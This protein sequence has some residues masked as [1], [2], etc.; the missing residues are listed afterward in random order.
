[1]DSYP[2]KANP[3]KSLAVVAL[4]P[5]VITTFP[6]TQASA[7][8]ADP[9]SG[10][11]SA[12][13]SCPKT[14][15]GVAQATMANSQGEQRLVQTTYQSGIATMVAVVS[16]APDHKNT[17]LIALD[18]KTDPNP[19]AGRLAALTRD[20]FPEVPVVKR[21]T[22]TASLDP[23]KRRQRSS[24]GWR[25]PSAEDDGPDR[26]PPWSGQQGNGGCGDFL[27]ALFGNHGR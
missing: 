20:C 22:D 23:P 6:I 19:L 15:T 11:A 9:L 18:P 13:L 1:M 12:G 2:C 7:A 21:G 17:Y 14:Q 25:P 16:Q 8:E 5:L 4:L 27:C 24:E 3:A 26:Y 10:F